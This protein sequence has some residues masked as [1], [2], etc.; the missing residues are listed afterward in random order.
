[1][2]EIFDLTY[3]LLMF[4]SR[5]TGFS[6]KEINIIIWFIVIPLSWAFLID[7]IR[8]KHF[9]KIGFIAII[10]LALLFIK[11]FSEFSNMAF[12]ASAEFL[13]GFDSIGSN[14]T[15]T[16]VVICVLAP[17]IIYIILIRKAYFRKM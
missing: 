3:K 13:R 6:Y 12:D 9:F 1:M 14:Y 16:S 17:L 15:T 5:I 2:K 7:K 10:I 11:D 4:L 8:G